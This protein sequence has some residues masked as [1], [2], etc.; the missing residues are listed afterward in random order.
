MP[1]REVHCA[2]AN[3]WLKT[4]R[5]LKVIITSLPDMEEVGLDFTSWLNWVGN[6]C[7]NLIDSLHPDGIIFFYQTDRRYSGEVV[8]KKT[9]ISSI[10][11]SEG[12]RNIFSKVVLKQEPNTTSLYRPTYTNLFA[13]SRTAQ[14]G[15]ATPD[16]FP[17]GRMLYKNAMGYDAVAKCI[18]FLQEKNIHETI[19]D[20]FCGQGSVL[21]IANALNFNAVGVDILPDQVERAKTP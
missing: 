9:L 20:P 1:T 10:F 17:A 7:Y 2:D 4:H 19:F 6:T 13:F 16:V 11:L 8:D 21:K 5:N 18:Q 3:I 14:A 12:Y 15:K